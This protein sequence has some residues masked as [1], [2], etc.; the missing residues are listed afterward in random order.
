MKITFLDG[1]NKEFENGLSSYEIAKSISSS[2]AKR[3]ILL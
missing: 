2:L 3:S 1:S